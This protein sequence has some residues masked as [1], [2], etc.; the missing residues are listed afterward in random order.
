[1][2]D[3]GQSLGLYQEWIELDCFNNGLAT[4][5]DEDF[6]AAGLTAEDRA[7]L[8]YLATQEEG[9]A[10]LLSNMLGETAPPQCV[11]DYPYKSTVSVSLSV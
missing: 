5:S 10:T 4:F 2:T 3:I 6:L 8:G 7:L 1:M 9:H 11:Y